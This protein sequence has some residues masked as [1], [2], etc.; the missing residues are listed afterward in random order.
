MNRTVHTENEVALIFSFHRY[1]NPIFLQETIPQI[2]EKR[3]PKSNFESVCHEARLF[4]G[5]LVSQ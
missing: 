4:N 1:V 5:L 2:E 3:K